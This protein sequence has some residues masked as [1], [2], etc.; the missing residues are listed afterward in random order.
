MNILI[1]YILC[2]CIFATAV[3]EKQSYAEIYKR[4]GDYLKKYDGLHAE[5]TIQRSGSSTLENANKIGLGYDPL[6][7]SLVCYTGAC[8]MDGFRQPLFKLNFIQASQGSCTTKLVPEHVALDC[9]ASSETQASTEVIDTLDRL[10][11]TIAK[12]LD[13][14]FGGKYQTASFSYKYSKETRYMIDNLVQGHSEILHTTLKLTYL[15]LS[16]FEPFMNMSDAFRYVIDQ[17]PCCQLDDAGIAEK[18]IQDYILEYFGY[19]YVTTL[20]LGGIAL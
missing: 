11:E 1:Q 4:V 12:G 7:G 15:K 18:Y 17:L 9:I 10:K 19:S 13:V 16:M 2:S 3:S 6:R 5:T 14:G 8:Q 20:M